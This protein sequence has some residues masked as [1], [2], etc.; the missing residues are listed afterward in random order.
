[1]KWHE[2]LTILDKRISAYLNLKDVT[3]RFHSVHFTGEKLVVSLTDPHRRDLYKCDLRDINISTLNSQT[4][5]NLGIAAGKAIAK[6]LKISFDY[7]S[8]ITH[9]HEE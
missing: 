6:N 8:I 5:A 1:M 9:N 3:P 2:I 7:P 4:K